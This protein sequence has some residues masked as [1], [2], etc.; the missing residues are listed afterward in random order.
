MPPPKKDRRLNEMLKTI[1]DLKIEFN[2]EVEILK[3]TQAQ[4]KM[5]WKTQ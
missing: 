2:K 5:E 3:K 4:I 1:Q